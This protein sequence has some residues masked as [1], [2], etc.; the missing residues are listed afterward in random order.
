MQTEYLIYNIIVAA[1]PVS[2]SFDRKVHFV[3]HWKNALPALAMSAIPFLLWDIVVSG[4]HWWFNE[5][6][7]L[8]LRFLGLPVEEWLF[9]LTV[10]FACIFV[11]EVFAAYFK[12][13]PVKTQT[14]I[15]S[16]ISALLIASIASLFY[17]KEY[18]ALATFILAMVLFL[19][20][21]TKTGILS[22]LRGLSIIFTVTILMLIFNGYLTARPVVLY[23]PSFQMNWRIY[24]IPVEDFLFGYSHILLTLIFYLKLKGRPHVK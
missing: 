7:T 3:S 1:G 5:A 15:I 18:T 24:T 11:W 8:G 4:R 13:R 21:Y 17:D 20:I 23:D 16:A 22:S 14:W 10:P 6:Y 19:D 2:L 9:F 12:D